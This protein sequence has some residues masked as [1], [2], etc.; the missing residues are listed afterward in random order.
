MHERTEPPAAP[1]APPS[2]W[3]RA[4]LGSRRLWRWWALRDGRPRGPRA[5]L[6]VDWIARLLLGLVALSVL[7][8]AVLGVVPPPTTAFMVR[9]GFVRDHPGGIRYEWVSS[10]AISGELALAVIASEDQRFPVHHGFDLVEIQKALDESGRRRGA[11]TLSQ[12][13]AKNLFL[14]PGGWVRKGLEAYLTVLIETLWPKRR[15]LEVYLNVAEFGPGVFGAE[16]ASR[17]YFGKGASHLSRSEAARLAAVLPSPRRM[18]VAR[19]SDY[20]R[21]RQ[22]EIEEGMAQL[23]G[24]SYLEGIW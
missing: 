20:V 24:T 17:A 15:I 7:V 9:E 19:P 23:G 22:R 13:V 2:P 12:Q 4:V 14:W 3:R 16:A 8:V 1:D 21:E 11:S 10:G 18:S 6:V 5:R